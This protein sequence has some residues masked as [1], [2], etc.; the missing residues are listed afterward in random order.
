MIQ[1]LTRRML[2]CATVW[3][4]ILLLRFVGCEYAVVLHEWYRCTA[5]AVVARFPDDE[6]EEAL[7]AYR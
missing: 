7:H 1:F 6:D 3:R 5:L 2:R 4:P